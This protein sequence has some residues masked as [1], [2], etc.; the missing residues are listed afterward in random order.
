MKEESI[1]HNFVMNALLGASGFVFQLISYPYA[2]RILQ[3]EGVGRVSFVTSVIAYLGMLAQLG[4]PTYGIRACARVRDDRAELSRTV[5]ELLGITLV[6][7][8][9]AYAL[10]ALAVIFVPRIGEERALAAIIGSTILMNSIGMEWLYKALEKYR[11]MAYR[12]LAFKIIALGALFLLVRKETDVLVYGGISIFA[13][14]AANIMNFIHIRKYVTFRK[15]KERD[16]KRHLRPVAVFFAISCAATVYTHLDTL[17]LGFMASNADVGYYDAAVKIK[18]ILASVVTAL[19][20]VVLP[21][22]SYYIEQGRMAEFRRITEKSFR[23]VLV[24]ASGV[25]LYF[26]LYAGESILLFSGEGFSE[27]AAPMRIILP[28]VLLIGMT[29]LTGIQIL[30]PMGREKVVLQ[31]EIAGVAADLILNALLIP[32][33]RAAGAAVGT[34]A[35]EAVVLAVQGWALRKEIGPVIRNYPWAKPA[36][37]LA[38]GTAACIWVKATGL[39]PAGVLAVSAVCFFGGYGAVLLWI[40]EPFAAETLGQIRKKRRNG[41]G[42]EGRA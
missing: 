36:I 17:M 12:S 25:A 41:T 6:M 26:M 3:P 9:V 42:G 8:A 32:R 39:G 27:A 10:L 34:L 30:V 2:S 7:N 5:Q 18:T 28:T 29:N 24:C 16:W 19:G 33:Y 21:R 40:R 37:A 1:R 20:A 15:Q 38:A 14:S 11:Y 22:S 31:S 4:I 13:S 35:A 23:F